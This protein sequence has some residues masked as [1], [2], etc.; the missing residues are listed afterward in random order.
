MAGS[1][2]GEHVTGELTPGFFRLIEDHLYLLKRK[3][4]FVFLKCNAEV[5][6]GT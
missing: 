6:H 5:S 4:Q 2:Y 1:G 3:E